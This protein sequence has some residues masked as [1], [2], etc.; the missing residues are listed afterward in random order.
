MSSTPGGIWSILNWK[1]LGAALRGSASG[2]AIAAVGALGLLA[3]APVK[4]QVVFQ[5]AIIDENAP[6]M[7][8]DGVQIPTQLTYP[9]QLEPKCVPG[10]DVECPGPPPAA[11]PG[12]ATAVYSNFTVLGGDGVIGGDVLE[13]DIMITNNSTDAYLTAFA[14]QSKFSESPALASRIGDKLFY[15]TL[16]AGAHPSGPLLS[17]KKNGT[18][19]GLFSGKWKGICINSSSDFI[20]EF[21]SGLEDESLECA[22]NRADE[23]NDGEPEILTT[24]RGLAPGQ[25]Q[26]VRVRLDSGTT[27]G[28]LHVVQPGTIKGRVIGTPFVGPNGITYFNVTADATFPDANVLEVVEF[29]DNKVLRQ[30]DGTFDPT[31]APL[32]D[33]LTFDKQQYLTLPRR[34][35]A[36]TDLLGRNHTCGTYGLSLGACSGGAGT[37]PMINVLDS[38]DLVPSVQ[39]LA[40]ILQ[41]FG[42]FHDPNN[43]FTPDQNGPAGEFRPSF[44]YGVLCENCGGKPYVPVAEFYRNNTDGT[45]TRY[46]VSGSYGTL[47]GPDQYKATVGGSG[48]LIKEEI[49]PEQDPGGPCR[50]GPPNLPP[51][52]EDPP[53]GQAT[54]PKL[55][56]KAFARFRDIEVIPGIGTTDIPGGINGG[57][58]IMFTIDITNMSGCPASPLPDEAGWNP[59]LCTGNTYLTA[60]NYQTK[61]R[62]LADIGTLDGFTQ[63]RRDIRLDATLDP[64]TGPEEGACWNAALGVGHFPNVIG[65]GLLFGQMVW[66]QADAGTIDFPV[67]TDQVYVRQTPCPAT[68]TH[69]NCGIDPIPTKLESVKKNGP[70]SPILKGNV[71]FICVKTGLFD[72]DPDADAGCSG[73]PDSGQP[74]GLDGD[75]VPIYVPT[76]TSRLGLAPGETQS[77][78]MRMEFGDFRGAM[79]RIASGTLTPLNVD[80]RYP[81]SGLRPDGQPKVGGLGRFFDCSDQ[82]ELE[83]CHPDLVGTNIGY[84]PNTSATWRTPL[85]LEEIEYVIINQ[86]GDAPTVM[87]FQQNFGYILAMAGFRPSAEF[88]APDPNPELATT[89]FA[90]GLIRQ[91][92]LGSY[93]MQPPFIAPMIVSEAVTTGATGAPYTYDVNAT[94]YPAATYSLTTAPEG[95]SIDQMTGMI[96]WTPTAG[97]DFPVVVQASNQA[98]AT[99]QSFTVSIPEALASLPDHFDRESTEW[100]KGRWRGSV[101]GYNVRND[102]LKVNEGGPIVWNRPF[103]K[104]QTA[105]VKLTKIDTTGGRHGLLLKKRG[106]SAIR[107][108]Y[109]ATGKTGHIIVESIPRVVGNANNPKLVYTWT[110]LANVKHVLKDGDTLSATASADGTVQVFA[111]GNPVAQVNAGSHFV[112]RGGRIGLWFEGA[113]KA[114]ADD[115]DGEGERGL[116]TAASLGNTRQ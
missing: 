41:G 9:I 99:T 107:V 28:G 102:E 103:G 15:G 52:G 69:S 26:T 48:A 76:A 44:P 74:V 22:G 101:E 85:T 32:A 27:D 30:A 116:A 61:Q 93:L 65:N 62:G 104:T 59:G 86:P 39:N 12:T 94:A 55:G 111:N 42:E 46:M 18:S 38:G 77:V 33:G 72:L 98:G 35:F 45:L 108:T 114:I 50:V 23:N 84:L 7:T 68:G 73:L 8:P 31:F 25:S 11:S 112:D 63:D 66:T 96:T 81:A 49:I 60:F 56:G 6:I 16:V 21:N 13:F 92:V 29:G 20:A 17:V 109:H 2:I 71:N 34:N 37:S 58:A 70:F 87:N 113:S 54:C 88:Y 89:S 83:Y 67:D 53:P 105:S 57:D 43:D 1:T 91:Q 78:R 40:A 19:N 47:G 79:L 5:R 82:R 115:F 90:G 97:G 110:R 95:M 10:P 75:G 3:S 36:F 14:F 51:D 80:P 100:W 106:L 64:C 24:I 4:A